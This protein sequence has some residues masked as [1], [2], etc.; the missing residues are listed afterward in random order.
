MLELGSDATMAKRSSISTQQK[1]SSSSTDHV[2]GRPYANI[3]TLQPSRSVEEEYCAKAKTVPP[4]TRAQHRMSDAIMHKPKK[5][6]PLVIQLMR[7]IST[8][9][10]GCRMLSSCEDQSILNTSRSLQDI[11]NRNHLQDGLGTQFNSDLDVTAFT[12]SVASPLYAN[13][14]VQVPLAKNTVMTKICHDTTR[15]HNSTS[16]LSTTTEEIPETVNDLASPK[17]YTVPAG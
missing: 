13:L 16:S 2:T 4:C 1:T 17:Y 11:S 5:S 12:T 6:H 10:E 9:T 14:P 7:K 15:G 8:E 3:H